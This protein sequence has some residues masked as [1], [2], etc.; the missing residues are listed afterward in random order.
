METRK[1]SVGNRLKMASQLGPL[2]LVNDLIP[3]R[4]FFVFPEIG[5][6]RSR[7]NIEGSRFTDSIFAYKPHNR[8]LFRN[9]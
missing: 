2:E 9:G 1:S 6:Q 8:V 4:G 3:V 7:K 5:F